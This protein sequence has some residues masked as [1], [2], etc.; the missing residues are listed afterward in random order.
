M[1]RSIL[2]RACCCKGLEH[3]AFTGLKNTPKLKEVRAQTCEFPSWAAPSD[4]VIQDAGQLPS[5]ATALQELHSTAEKARVSAGDCQEQ[6]TKVMAEV[7]WLAER[8]Q[9][10]ETKLQASRNTLR[11]AQ[12]AA[13]ARVQH[14]ERLTS[15]VTAGQR[16]LHQLTAQAEAATQQRTTLIAKVGALRSKRSALMKRLRHAGGDSTSVGHFNTTP[17]L[18]NILKGEPVSIPASASPMPVAVRAKPASPAPAVVATVSSLFYGQD[19]GT[20]SPPQSSV[21]SPDAAAAAGVTVEVLEL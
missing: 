3:G 15:E 11:T 14:M 10:L 17:R 16:K 2:Q 20:N 12:Q 1:K 18:R 5:A 7:S 6:Y 13:N 9:A 21:L 4:K 8:V 19:D